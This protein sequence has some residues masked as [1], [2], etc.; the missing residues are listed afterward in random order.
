[1]HLNASDLGTNYTQVLALVT[2]H[3]VVT[4][5]RG[6]TGAVTAR[7]QATP[8]GE[9]RSM[10]FATPVGGPMSGTPFGAEAELIISLSTNSLP[11]TVT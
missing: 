6:T 7:S 4:S 8:G 11:F 5:E 1:M 3:L 9:S 10:S 2:I